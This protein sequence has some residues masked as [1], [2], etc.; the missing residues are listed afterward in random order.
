MI[1]VMIIEC[2]SDCVSD[3][4]VYEIRYSTEYMKDDKAF[5]K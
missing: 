3:N 4:L 5:G 1:S 2:G